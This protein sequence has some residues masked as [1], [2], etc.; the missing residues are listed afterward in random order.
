MQTIRPIAAVLL[1]SCSVHAQESSR[2]VLG[3]ELERADATADSV[4]VHTTGA[5]FV[6][7]KAGGAIQCFQ[8]IPLRRK[9]AVVT[10]LSLQ[11]LRIT[12]NSK[13]QCRLSADAIAGP[14]LIALDSLLTIPAGPGA[15][16]AIEGTYAPSWIGMEKPHFLLPD[17]NGGVGTYLLG[18]GVCEV[19]GDWKA[20]WTVRYKASGRGRVLV[21]VFPPRP[22]DWKRSGE[23]MLHSFSCT[24][25]YP[26]D[27][28]LEE[29]ATVGKSLILHSWI[30]E[31]AGGN[32]QYGVEMDKSWLNSQFVPK[33]EEE[34]RRVARTAHR[35]KMKVLPY[36][37]PYYQSGGRK[38]ADF[39]RVVGEVLK[40]YDLDGVYFDGVHRDIESAYEVTRQVRKMIGDDGVLCIHSTTLPL[41]RIYCP[42][43]D[44]YADYILRGE[45]VGISK[46]YARWK[47]SCFNLSNAVGTFCYDTYRVDKP[48][49]DLLFSVHARLPLWVQDGTWRGLKYHLTEDEMKLMRNEYL[50][51]LAKESQPPGQHR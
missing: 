24:H 5:E 39:A 40:K 46:D 36:M 21:S 31:G 6:L 4:T 16:V 25:P 20:G 34:L 19:S 51:R 43:L 29:W 41:N 45:H 37:S 10:G 1:L 26:S 38:P 2:G 17:E 15:T 48:M 14:I 33:S 27:R 28:E 12:A 30:W 44:C 22:Y 23:T 3:M 32:R 18:D 13:E 35:L 49:I 8:R 47:V 7:D 9:V 50:P 42:F 11:G